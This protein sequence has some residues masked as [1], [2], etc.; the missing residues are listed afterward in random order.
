MAEVVPVQVVVELRE[1]RY[2]KDFSGSRLPPLAPPTTARVFEGR[3]ARIHP[4]GDPLRYTWGDEYR[5]T[6]ELQRIV[7][8]LVGKPVTLLHPDGLISDGTVAKVV[9][10]IIGARLDGEYAVATIMITDE[11]GLAA[12]EDG[13]TLELSLGYTSRLDEARHQRDVTVDHLALVPRARCGESCALRADCA[14][15]ATPCGCR[16]TA[17]GPVV[18]DAKPSLKTDVQAAPLEC[19][20]K[21]RAM[22][23]SGLHMADSTTNSEAPKASLDELQ[24]ALA[25]SIADA[26]AQK[27]RADQAEALAASE[28]KRADAAE[29]D[30]HNAKKDL[31]SEKAN[32]DAKLAE[33]T[34]AADKARMDAA[35]VLETQ[36]QERVSILTEANKVLG[37]GD[38]VKQTNREI[39][40]AIV[41]HVDGD[42]LDEKKSDDFVNGAYEGAL[43]RHAKS[44]GSRTDARVAIQQL[45]T[46][47]AAMITDPREAERAEMHAA[48]KRTAE[49]WKTSSKN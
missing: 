7:D 36:V 4:D 11:A 15:D 3:V 41:K 35:G 14:A 49:A 38:R 30:A 16:E 17:L 18:V 21:T 5:D 29:L 26:T 44:A 47:G 20:C 23:H 45:R 10:K 31:E 27:L 25:D 46:D 40:I 32:L 34:A 6:A 33:A 43:R 1:V 2:C 24:K 8:Q 22:P 42:D 28:K 13:Q 48:N 9:G 19:P 37:E 39:K 12:I